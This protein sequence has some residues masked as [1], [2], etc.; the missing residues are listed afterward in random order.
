MSAELNVLLTHL[1]LDLA[2]I[3]ARLN[4]LPEGEAQYG[5]AFSR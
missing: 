3:G 2:S 1:G 5:M 4:Q